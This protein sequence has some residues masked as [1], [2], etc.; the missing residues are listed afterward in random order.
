VT[1]SDDH[2]ARVWDAQTGQPLSPPLQHQFDVKSASFSPDGKWVVTASWDNTARVWD[3]SPSS[4]S[5][6]WLPDALEAYA[7][8]YLDDSGTLHVYS[9]EKFN[10]IRQE[11]LDSTSNDPWEIFGRWLFSDPETRTIS[12][13]S[14]VTVP[15]Y[16]AR[17]VEAAKQAAAAPTPAGAG[18]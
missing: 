15:D 18:H 5:P 11:R 6:N 4:D 7:F 2:T 8:Q 17:E 16:L 9:A 12:P 10:R 13:W 3:M 14:S 1:A